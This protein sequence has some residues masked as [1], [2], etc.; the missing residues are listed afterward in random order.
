MVYCPS[1]SSGSGA[2]DRL[3]DD[4]LDPSNRL[5]LNGTSGVLF[6]QRRFLVP[7]PAWSSES[8]IRP[9]HVKTRLCGEDR[10]Q[11]VSRYKECQFSFI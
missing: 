5:N 1:S 7:V 8:E 11:L 9:V 2:A 3:E 4:Q 6:T 10:S